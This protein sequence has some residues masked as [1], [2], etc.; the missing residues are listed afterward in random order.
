MPGQWLIV[1][2][3]FHDNLGH[4][5]DVKQWFH[6]ADV[7]KLSRNQSS[8]RAVSGATSDVL[9]IASLLPGAIA[10]RPL[11][12]DSDPQLQGWWSPSERQLLPNFAFS[13][14]QNGVATGAFATLFSFATD[15]QPDLARS[16]VNASGRRSRLRWRDKS[17][18]HLLDIE[19]AAEGELSVHYQSKGV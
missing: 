3:W 17:Q 7:W 13:Y 8:Y 18:E 9:S 12:G 11:L 6:L 1:F 4:T 2:D 14:D 16:R 10:S 15:L 5:H 19:R